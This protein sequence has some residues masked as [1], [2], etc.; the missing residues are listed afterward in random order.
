[1]KPLISDGLVEVL[2]NQW[3]HE[4]YNAGLYLYIASFLEGKGLSNLSKLFRS[5][6][7]EEIG[8]SKI[9]FD[10]LSDLNVVVDIPSVEGC[11]MPIN[12]IGDIA[13]MYFEREVL[14]TESL[15]EIRNMAME[16]GNGIVEEKIRETI[17]LQQHEMAEST[18]FY[19]KSELTGGN[20]QFAHLS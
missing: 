15:T 4:R 5:Q 3:S 6:H 1:M 11:N 2:M 18:E 12:S 14:T 9:I 19:D 13:K 16:E 20:W 7:D 10:L 17:S 8:H